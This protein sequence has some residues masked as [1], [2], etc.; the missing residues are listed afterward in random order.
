MPT[1]KIFSNRGVA[2][3]PNFAPIQDSRTYFTLHHTPADT[4]DKIDLHEFKENAA[5]VA[6]LGYALANSTAVLPRQPEPMPDW[7]K[8]EQEAYSKASMP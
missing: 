6:V 2:G 3:V 8:E 5:A 4:F 7:L 1:G